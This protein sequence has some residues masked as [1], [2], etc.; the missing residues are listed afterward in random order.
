V[1]QN[2]KGV[3]RVLLV[4]ALDPV[5]SVR[6]VTGGRAR[7]EIRTRGRGVDFGR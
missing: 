2:Q 6:Q 5:G 3:T 4:G 1:N 7:L